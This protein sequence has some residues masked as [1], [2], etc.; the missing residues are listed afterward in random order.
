MFIIACV[1]SILLLTL[2]IKTQK[3]ILFQLNSE[4][5][6][7]YRHLFSNKTVTE[8]RDDFKHVGKTLL[9]AF[10]QIYRALTLVVYWLSV[11]LVSILLPFVVYCIAIGNSFFRKY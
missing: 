7:F 3:S 10:K 9:K 2:I 1:L 6:A 8:F 4:L 5:K 11:P